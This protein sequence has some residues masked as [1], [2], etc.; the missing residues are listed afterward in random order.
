MNIRNYICIYTHIWYLRYID[1]KISVD[2]PTEIQISL[3]KRPP[4]LLPQKAFFHIMIHSLKCEIRSEVH[5]IS[6]LKFLMFW[7]LDIVGL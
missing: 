5:F 6:S 4:R 7:T 1:T 3:I 2:R